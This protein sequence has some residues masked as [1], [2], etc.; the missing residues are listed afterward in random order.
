MKKILIFLYLLVFSSSVIVHADAPTPTPIPNGADSAAN[1]VFLPFVKAP[2]RS[3]TPTLYTNADFGRLPQQPRLRRIPHPILMYIIYL[4][5]GMIITLET[6][7]TNPGLPSTTP[8]NIS[9]RV[10]RSFC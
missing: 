9:I 3:T 2:G 1:K 10:I 4:P 7:R 5:P 8:G 6:Q